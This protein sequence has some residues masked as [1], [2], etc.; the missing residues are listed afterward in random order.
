MA[1]PK[2]LYKYTDDLWAEEM[3]RQS[4]VWRLQFVWW[5]R[6]CH[7]SGRLMW[8]ET[9]YQHITSDDRRYH[10]TVEHLIWMLKGK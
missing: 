4:P 6:R 9:A 8:L 1:M 2:M 10:S 3:W 7:L 5:P